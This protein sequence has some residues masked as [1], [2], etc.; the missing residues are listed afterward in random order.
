VQAGDFSAFEFDRT[1]VDRM[2]TDDGIEQRG[3]T[4]TVGADQAG[5]LPGSIV[6][7][8]ALFAITPP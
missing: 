4:G 8:T 6:S 5:D 3:F 2:I 1:G 7:E